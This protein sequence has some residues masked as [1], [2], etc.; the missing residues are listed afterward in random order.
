MPVL[1]VFIIGMDESIQIF[2]LILCNGA[3][4]KLLICIHDVVF[5]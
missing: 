2:F 1:H 3:E 4:A 5:Y